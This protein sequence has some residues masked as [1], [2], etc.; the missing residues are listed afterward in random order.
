M[1]IATCEDCV[2][3]G[4]FCRVEALTAV[5]TSKHDEESLKIFKDSSYDIKVRLSNVDMLNLCYKLAS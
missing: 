5:V 1:Y 4:M 3:H 2:H